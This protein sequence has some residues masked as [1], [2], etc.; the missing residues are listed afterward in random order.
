MSYSVLVI[1]G[2]GYIGSHMCQHL[3]DHNHEVTVFDNFS[4]GHR[5]AV[6]SSKVA[7][8]DIRS[9]EDLKHCLT[10]SKFDVAMHFAGLAYVAESV[11]CPSDYYDVNL[12]GTLTLLKALL[13]A[14]VKRLVFSSTCSTYGDADLNKISEDH[15]QFPVNPYGRSKWMV[16]QIL[17]DYAAAHAFSSISL[18]YFNAAGCDLEGRLGERHDPETHL[19]PRI[20]LEALRVRQGGDPHKTSLKVYGTTLATPDGTCVRDFIH[21]SDLCRAH[22]SAAQRL[23]EGGAV[24]AEFY[25]LGLGRGCSVLEVIQASRRVTGI[26]I[27]YEKAAPRPGDPVHLVSDAT[28]ANDILGWRPEITSL[29][30]IIGS[31]WNWLLKESSQA[32]LK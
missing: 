17:K 23:V 19:I 25:N 32:V 16:E 29:E 5:D 18:R 22:M 1:G 14:D 15:P 28:R 31:A 2:G 3:L 8:G 30:V 11:D 13:D 4:R 12:R 20:L 6:L 7:V 21:V 10:G 24:G 9:H 27:Q 26:D